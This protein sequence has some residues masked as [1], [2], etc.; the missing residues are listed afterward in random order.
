MRT[1]RATYRVQLNEGFTFAD[2]AEMVPYLAEL[3][4]SDLYASPYMK[5]RPGSTHG[6]DVI[7]HN[8]LNPEIG[9][10][11]DYERLIEVLRG[12]D[13]GQLLDIVPNHMGVGSDNPWWMDVLEHG[14]ASPYADYFD[15]DW[16]PTNRPG[17]HGKVLLP[18]LGD[19]YRNV[20]ENGELKLGFDLEDGS[21]SVSYYEHR[22]PLD[23]KSYPM[24]LED[25]EDLPDD[26]HALE[27]ESLVTAFGNLPARDGSDE[28]AVAELVRDS[29]INKSRLA[30]LCKES[31][32]ISRAIEERVGELNG[33][34]GEPE[35]FEELHR[36]LEEQAYRLVFWRVASDEINYRRF[37][38][39]ND[40]AGVRVEDEAVFEDTHRFILKLVAD[41]KVQGLRIDHPDGLYDPAGYFRRLQRATAEALG[42]EEV[43]PLYVLG[44]K[45][46]AHHE[47]L[48][49][50]WPIAGTTGYEFTNL[51][52]GLFVDADGETG[53]D[54]AYRR[55]IGRR[56]DF[57][58]LL[59]DCKRLIMKDALASELNVLSR[60]LLRIA[61]GFSGR[62][63]H[64]F[65]INA[66]RDA[67]TEVV[68]EFPVYRTYASEGGL[69]EQD[70]R[71]VEWAIARARK[72]STAADTTVFDF[73]RD[74]LLLNMGGPEEYRRLAL[75]FVMKFQQYTG[76]VM[77]KG[78]EDTALYAYN[79]LASLNE[80]G[81][82][83]ERFGV[84]PSAFHHLNAERAKHWP[85][86]MLASSTHDTKR[87]EDVRA[88]INVLS[89]MPGE[90]RAALVRWGRLNR[91]RRR[92][93][94]G[95]PAPS[96]NDEYLLYQTLLGAWPLE[97]MREDSLAAFSERIR[98][99]MEKAMREAQVHTSWTKVN[100]EYESAVA[101]FVEAVL[102][103]ENN[104]FL[105]DFL[106]FQRRVAR[107]G[108]LNSLSQTLLKLTVPGVPDIYQGN[109]LW[110]LSLVDP[111][112]RR[113]V[114]Y[115]M[116]EKLLVGL[117]SGEV[118]AR[119]LLEESVWRDGRPKLY[120]TWKTLELRRALTELFEHGEYLP[121]EV[122]GERVDHLVAF[123]RRKRDD[124]LI[125]VS[126]RRHANLLGDEDTLLP[127]QSAWSDTRVV[128][129]ED[130]ASIEL[131]NVFT[132]ETVTGE[133]FEGDVVL[134]AGELLQGFPVALLVT[135]GR[136]TR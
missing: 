125:S 48:P 70:E 19:H 75:A 29:A 120:L 99:Y 50:D 77:A 119:S 130:F 62:R 4:I 79:R 21:F 8:S 11:E 64:D 122:A 37:F 51:V 103:T 97:E 42:S 73:I 112:N 133:D 136:F 26:E 9:S 87:G 76:P 89:E 36:L 44:E 92:E 14:P 80:V 18:V 61:G 7:D 56:M 58:R 131:R 105:D 78:M 96:R 55:F 106:P 114:D 91:S 117:K 28:E 63:T 30:R 107:L 31:G 2:A 93:I 45:I 66:L 132:G 126:S 88:R 41:G 3:G 110:D 113:P 74:V 128:L 98:A 72:R 124:L 71:Y 5:A 35:S 134:R 17:L 20:L 135:D 49:E 109:E 116:R 10:E 32:A 102:A 52:N 65:T 115:G 16:Y 83:P 90:W 68:A 46:L 25:L 34:A 67:L 60:R 85:H 40:L 12:H 39:I 53:M 84:S 111:D 127:A 27:F 22:C 23:P 43:Q 6:Y 86:A 69:S 1:P 104:L 54:R 81:G 33:E 47:H 123:A 108:A 129:P 82:E 38:A 24:I 95:E 15:I 100:E 118:D 94:D 57:E 121:F 13:M 59:Y 101:D